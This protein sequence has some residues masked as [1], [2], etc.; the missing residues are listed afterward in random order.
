MDNKMDKAYLFFLALSSMLATTGDFLTQSIE[1]NVESAVVSNTVLGIITY[2]LPR[3]DKTF[4]KF[5][6]LIDIW[7][8][9]KTEV[10][11]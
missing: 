5:A 8:L 11:E 2:V 6:E 1:V 10:T 9:K 3:L 7:K 4:M